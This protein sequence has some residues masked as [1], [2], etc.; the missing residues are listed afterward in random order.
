MPLIYITGVSGSGKT[1]VSDELN[2]RGYES[3]DADREGYNYWHDKKSHKVMK[4]LGKFNVHTPKFYQKYEWLMILPKVEDLAKRAQNRTIFLCGVCA[5][6]RG[7]YH[8]FSKVIELIIDENMLR[9]RIANRT[10]NKFGQAPH[11]L[12]LILGWHKTIIPY[13]LTVDVT[14]PLDK[15]VDEILKIATS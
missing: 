11:E 5:N 15:V 12:E 3:R 9:H 6:E 14:Q 13:S 7:M 8:L 1:A 2:K 4:N 10:T